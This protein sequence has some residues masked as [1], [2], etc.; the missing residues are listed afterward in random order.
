MHETTHQR[1][2][3]VVRIWQEEGIVWRGWVQHAGSQEQS[4]F[5]SVPELVDFIQHYT[6]GLVGLVEEDSLLPPV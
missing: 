1:H 6:E 5:Q 2:A 3:F 4:Y